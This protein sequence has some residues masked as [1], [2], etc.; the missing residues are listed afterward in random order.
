MR[1]PSP[2]NS[3]ETPEA[4]RREVT[5]EMPRRP[6]DARKIVSRPC[7]HVLA[8]ATWKSQIASRSCERPITV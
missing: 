6:Q 4:T 5:I 3:N 7:E 2:A 1:W 8:T